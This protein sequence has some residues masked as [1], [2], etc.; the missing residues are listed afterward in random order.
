[1]F[2]EVPCGSQAVSGAKGR[3]EVFRGAYMAG[4]W[5]PLSR[6][7]IIFG[8]GEG[9]TKPRN[10]RTRSELQARPG[11]RIGRC[12]SVQEGESSGLPRGGGSVRISSASSA[13]SGSGTGKVCLAREVVW[14]RQQERSPTRSATGGDRRRLSVKR[15][16]HVGQESVGLDRRRCVY[17]LASQEGA[18]SKAGELS[19]PAD[20]G[21]RASSRG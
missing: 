17:G 14:K 1:M 9:I 7:P 3:H 15:V 4:G 20:D 8:C 5:P 18:E 6:R 10:L 19:Y 12:S 2:P 21:A 11:G 16:V 13:G